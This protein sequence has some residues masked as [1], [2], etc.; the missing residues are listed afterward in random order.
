MLMIL[1]NA[2]FHVELFDV[3]DFEVAYFENFLNI[4]LSLGFSFA[5]NYF[6]CCITR[7]TKA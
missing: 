3:D 5:V 2:N 1:K 4:E 7:C 6:L